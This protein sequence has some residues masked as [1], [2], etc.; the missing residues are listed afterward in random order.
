MGRGWVLAAAGVAVGVAAGAVTWWSSGV[1][2]VPKHLLMIVID[3]Q[4]A[5]AMGVYGNEMGLTEATDGFAEDAVVF[6][7]AWAQGAYTI[8][9][10]LS[11]MTSTYTRTHGVDG[12]LGEGGICGWDD[13]V[14][15]PEYLSQYGFHSRAY[16]ANPNL[17]PK[18][19][20]PRGFD[21]WNE[22][23]PEHLG[24]ADLPKRKYFRGDRYVA[25][26]GAQQIAAWDASPD[27]R[28]FLYLHLMSPHLPLRPS[29]TARKV[30]GLPSGPSWNPIG[31]KDIRKLRK[32]STPAQRVETQLAYHA[33]V[34]DAD[35]H[36]ARVLDALREHGHL[37]DTVVVIMADH[38]EELW[39]HG[40]YGHQDG[41]WEPLVHV[42]LIIGSPNLE[43][44]RVSRPVGLIDVVPTVS[45]L[46]GLG[47]RAPGWQGED[48]FGWRNRG[49]TISERF[50]ER[51]VTR[52]GTRK[53]VW[54]DEV[55]G[56]HWRFF[57]LGDDPREQSPGDTDPNGLM[58]VAAGWEAEVPDVRRPRRMPYE[59][60]CGPLSD[61]EQ[62]E[63]SEALENLGYVDGEQ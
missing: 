26:K 33:S 20:F 8:A 60:I 17:H 5:D 37:E 11:Y 21:S 7:H 29:N 58:P 38:G 42:P 19:G 56:G 54:I 39:E 51:A 27:A 61:N 30:V 35:R 32:A 62:R 50:Q 63:L 47:A 59:G 3:T 28:Q 43:P 1:G 46:L 6:D 10:Y 31:I 14:M 36:V 34:Y 41:V 25:R 15:L 53:G 57:D 13:L 45:R 23:G 12:D 24:L 4:R 44:A 9:S 48:L 2:P 18:K 40:D 55:Q 52:D 49:W 22:L 16:V